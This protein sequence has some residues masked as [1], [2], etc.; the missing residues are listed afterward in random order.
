MCL[1]AAP[2]WRVYLGAAGIEYA[3]QSFVKAKRWNIVSSVYDVDA[4]FG[5]CDQTPFRSSLC[6]K[7]CLHRLFSD[8]QEHKQDVTLRPRGYNFSLPLF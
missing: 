5:N 8:I 3:E 6:G 1:Y 2:A 4:L 7:H